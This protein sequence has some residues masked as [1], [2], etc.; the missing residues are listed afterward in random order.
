[1]A[2]YMSALDDKIFDSFLY[3]LSPSTGSPIL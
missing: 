2:A 1:M 3:K